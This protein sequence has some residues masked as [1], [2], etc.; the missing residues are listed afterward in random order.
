[1]TLSVWF[2]LFYVLSIVFAVWREYA[3]GPYP[4]YKGTWYLVFYIMLGLLG[5]KVFGS[6]ITG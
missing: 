4:W 6:P 3:P 1:M 2:W 5:W